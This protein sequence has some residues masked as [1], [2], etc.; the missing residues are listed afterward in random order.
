MA[1]ACYN[2]LEVSVSPSGERGVDG[3]T[4]AQRVL[5]SWLRGLLSVEPRDG[6]L[7][8]F[9]AHAPLDSDGDARERWGCD[10]VFSDQAIVAAWV[11]PDRVML[12]FLTPWGPA[13]RW[14][15]VMAAK[16]SQLDFEY[17]WMEPAMGVYGAV[18]VEGGAEVYSKELTEADDE[19]AWAFLE[20]HHLQYAEPFSGPDS[21]TQQR[22]DEIGKRWS[23]QA[24][25]R[26]AR[27][28]FVALDW[29][30]MLDRARPLQLPHNGS[31]IEPR[32][33]GPL[34]HA[35]IAEMYGM[36]A[37]LRPTWSGLH[38]VLNAFLDT[39]TCAYPEILPLE[40][41]V[42]QMRHRGEAWVLWA[43]LGS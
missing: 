23:F 38:P 42:C 28:E 4:G 3:I 33:F 31:L 37:E 1:N 12:L 40:H 19:E 26:Q 43:T 21:E 5:L 29:P 27:A 22:W 24:M 17:M 32:P 39:F 16:E 15:R 30:K 14:F 8:D 6:H 10:G 20:E 9:S 36:V 2:S 7:I 25:P 34:H 41:P 35:M 18:R 11:A 13:S